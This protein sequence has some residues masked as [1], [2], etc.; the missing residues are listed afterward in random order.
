MSDSFQ[1][2]SH[3]AKALGDPNRLFILECLSQKPCAV[4]ELAKKTGFAVANLSHHLQILKY[5]GVARSTRKGRQI[6]YAIQ[7]K[8]VVLAV[9]ALRALAEGLEQEDTRV[10]ETLKMAPGPR[11]P[12][13]SALQLV[14]EGK[15]VVLDVRPLDEYRAGHI[16][17]ALHIPLSELTGR[18]EE[19][20]GDKLIVAY[21]RGPSCR[22][23]IEASDLLNGRGKPARPL[24]DGYPEWWATGHPVEGVDTGE[25]TF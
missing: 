13:D 24:E 21:C 5:A 20:P 23:A 17:G 25:G 15:A 10:T 12:R 1:S 3:L 16:R 14:R 2:L 18:L 8:E 6:I 11:I 4:D 7:G 22:L 9:Q 19:L